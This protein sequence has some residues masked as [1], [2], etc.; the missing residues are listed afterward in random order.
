MIDR[1]FQQFILFFD[2]FDFLVELVIQ[3]Y[4]FKFDRIDGIPCQF[5]AGHCLLRVFKNFLYQLFLHFSLVFVG[6]VL[7]KTSRMMLMLDLLDL[8]LA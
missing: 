6:H 3:L 8:L 5:L 1:L 2:L 4:L 7:A